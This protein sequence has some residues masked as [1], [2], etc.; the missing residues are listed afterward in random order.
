V[1]K[2]TNSLVKNTMHGT[3]N[4]AS[5]VTGAL[6]KG[7]RYL[8]FDEEYIKQKDKLTQKKSIGITEGLSEGGEALAKGIWEGFSG[9]LSKP[10]EGAT[11]TGVAGFFKGVGI[12]IMG[13]PT[14]TVAGLIDFTQKTTEGI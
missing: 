5:K 6:N 4:T 2:G 1:L 8:T 11:K 14:K 10:I 3:F 9:V 7:I 13:M 12:G